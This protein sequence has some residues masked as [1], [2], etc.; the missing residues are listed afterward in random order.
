M[1]C[2]GVGIYAMII[3]GTTSISGQ[4]SAFG[5]ENLGSINDIIRNKASG[6]NNTVHEQTGGI[7]PGIQGQAND[8]NNTVHGLANPTIPGSQG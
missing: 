3:F 1:I 5:I 7:G 4:A 2:S 6:V 8:V